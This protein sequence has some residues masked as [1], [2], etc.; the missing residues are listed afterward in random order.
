MNGRHHEDDHDVA[1]ILSVV[2]LCQSLNCL[3]NA[4]GLLDQDPFWVEAF[5][6]V[7]DAQNK[8]AE[9]ERNKGG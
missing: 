8:K 9:L 1:N 2:S 6:V 5:G 4:G 7:I 3:P